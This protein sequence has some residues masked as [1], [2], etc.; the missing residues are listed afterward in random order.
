MIDVRCKNCNVLLMKAEFCFVAIKCRSCKMIFEYKI[1]TN[2]H[3][4][5]SEDP[6]VTK[7]LVQNLEK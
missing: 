2:L 7:K 5:N 6:S 4:N 3:F 1:L